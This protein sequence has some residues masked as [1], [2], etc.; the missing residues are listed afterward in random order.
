MELRRLLISLGIEC[1]EAIRS[2]FNER[3]N[4]RYE[5]LDF[6]VKDINSFQSTNALISVLDFFKK[7][8]IKLTF[9]GSFDKAMG[10]SN[11]RDYLEGSLEKR[12]LVEKINLDLK[13]FY[14]RA[15]SC[16]LYSPVPKIVEVR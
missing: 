15:V 14:K 8:N 11:L 1:K 12:K 6:K 7:A 3:K 5:G 10:T 9:S 4:K 13:D 16:F 2:Y